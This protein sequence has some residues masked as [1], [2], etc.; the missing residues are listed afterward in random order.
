MS[1]P[2]GTTPTFTLSFPATTDLTQADNVYVSFATA[3]GVITKTG[4]SLEVRPSQIDVFLTQADTLTFPV[5]EIEIQA[6]WTQSGMRMASEIKTYKITKQLL[7]RE[8]T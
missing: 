6:N 4:A 1:I 2:R 7:T 3:N 8:I 5:G